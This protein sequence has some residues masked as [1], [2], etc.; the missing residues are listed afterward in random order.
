MNEFGHCDKTVLVDSVCYMVLQ[1]ELVKQDD[2]S[3]QH[4]PAAI[5]KFASMQCQEN[6][7]TML[8]MLRS[9]ALNSKTRLCWDSLR[10]MVSGRTLCTSRNVYKR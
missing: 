5:E 9:R 6:D 8:L 3:T 4:I 7:T 10:W 1:D 2:Y